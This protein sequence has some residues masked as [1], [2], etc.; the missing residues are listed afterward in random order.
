M[1]VLYANNA[2]SRLAASITNVATSFSVTAGHG[3]KFP[4]I[5]GADYF[6]ATLMDSAGNLEVVKVTARATD[7]FTVTRAQ[8]GTTAR[9]YAVNAIVEL[10]IT[11]AML[12]DFKT[13]T[14]TG[15]LPLAGGTL[16][17]NLN[18]NGNLNVGL[19]GGDLTIR[20]TVGNDL[21]DL[22][23]ADYAGT[24]KHRLWDGST[25]LLYR[26]NGGTGYLLI[27]AG[28]YNSYALP[29]SGG[30]ITT[31]GSSASVTIQDTGTNGA[32]IRLIGNGATTPNKFIRS[33]NGNLEIVNSGYTAVVLSVTDAGNLT[34]NGNVTAFSDERLKKD[35]AALPA[36]FIKRLAAVKS[37]TYTRVDSG[38][39]QAGSSAQDWQALLPE[40]ISEG[41]DD[42]KTLALAYGNA[43]LVSVVELAKDNLELRARIERLEA[44]VEKLIGD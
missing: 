14:R 2:A 35:W 22:V 12:D 20:A 9:A 31:S 41:A 21:G 34:A 11:K 43:A 39:R 28:N 19:G 18:V 3:A 44:L 13:D 25:G 40:V 23:W 16:T 30:T 15:Y 24:E 29:L 1:P 32:N 6:Y 26:N 5:S 10:R 42:N 4:V 36:D 38:E 7:T 27:H 37:G 33:F 8:E 17:G